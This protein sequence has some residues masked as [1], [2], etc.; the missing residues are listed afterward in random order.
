MSYEPIENHGII[1]D[2][3]TVALVGMNGSIDFLSFPAFD[4]PTVFAAL[5]DHRRGGRFQPIRPFRNSGPSGWRS[6]SL[7]NAERS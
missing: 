1:G 4:S 2:L 7:V 6:K 3:H 5:L